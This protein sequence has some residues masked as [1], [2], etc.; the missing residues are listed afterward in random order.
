MVSSCRAPRTVA[1]QDLVRD[2]RYPLY[3][4]ICPSRIFVAEVYEV[5]MLWT[6]DS[7][8]VPSTCVKSIAYSTVMLAELAGYS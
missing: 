5:I 2:E 1:C 3:F 6:T 4:S 7:A 8:K